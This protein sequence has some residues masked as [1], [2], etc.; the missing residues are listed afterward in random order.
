[1]ATIDDKVVSM[2][3]ESSKFEQGVNRTISSLEKLKAAL[4]FPT[5]GK[6]LEDID[7]A[8]KKVDFGLLARGIENVKNALNTLRL[9]GIGVLTHL[10]NVA[11]DTGAK[12]VKALTLDPIKAGFSE[13]TTNLNAV[14]TIL[15]NTQAAGVGL[16]EVNATL[17][18]LNAYSDK[19]IYNFSQMAKN[20]GT[21][22]AA[23]VDL[24]TATASIKG[25]ANLAALSGSSAEQAST[26]MYQ[27]S[28]AIAAGR[29]SLMDWNSVV[30]AG[31]GGTVFQR[32]LAQTAEAMGTLKDGTVK[33]VGPMKNVQ[34]AGESF[35][36]SLQ[37]GP[38]KASWL[39]SE[40]LTKTLQQFTGDLSDAEL[41]AMGFNDAQIKAI[42]QTAQTAMHAATEVKTLGQVF[43]VAKE[44]AG[45][46]WAQ[47]FQ[48]LFGTFT[49]AKTTFTALSNA[50]NGFI[51]TNADARNKVLEDWKALGGRTVLIDSIKT[52]FHNLGLIIAPIKEAFRD[53]FPA[54]TG[55]DLYNLTLRFR[56]FAN[57]LKP[58]EQTIENLKRTF[59][60][61]FALLDIGKQIISGIFGVF[62][63]LFG[64]VGEGSGGFL[65]FTG[66]IGDFLVK[67]DEAL[68]KGDGLNKFF[69]GLAAVLEVPI[70]L[71][72]IL[73]SALAN[74]FG[75]F[76]SGGFSEQMDGM[77]KAMTPFQ[78]LMAGITAAWDNFVDSF[79]NVGSALQPAVDAIIS[80]VDGLGTAI[81]QAATNMNFDAILQVIRTGLFAGLVLLLKNFF[82]KGSLLEQISKGFG[83]GIIANIAGS[84]KALEGS[85]VAMQQNI[86]A[87]TL[88]EIA[89]A[90]ALLAASVVALSFVDPAK[91][92]TALAAIGIMMGELLGAMAILDKI[93]KS[94]GFL[95]L[96]IIAAGLVILAGA[97]DLLVIAVF[98]LSQLSWEELLKGL[99][100][101]GALLLGISAASIPLSANS[102]GMI[103]AGIGIGAI[104]IAMNLLALAMK[105]FAGMSWG[106]IA[107]GLT[108]VASGLVVIAGAM[109]IMPTGMVLQGAAIIAIAT[110]LK[111]LAGVVEKFGGMNWSSM[112]KGMVGI[113]GALVIIAGA[114]Q[115]MPK[116]M[117]LQAAALLILS[118]ALGKIA[119]AVQSMGGMSLGEIAR[120]LGTLAG[121]L[122]ILAA[123]LYLMSG[124][125]AGAAALT[126][127]AAGL[128]LLVPAIVALGGMSWGQILKGL[129]TLAAALTIIGIAGALITPVIPSLLGLGAA[130]LLIGAGL[131]LAGAGI[132]LIGVG[133]SALIVALPAGVGVLLTALTELQEGIINNVKLL[134]LGLLEIVKALA[135]TAPQFVEALVTI[136]NSLLDV[137]IQASPK[138]A[139][140]FNA[141]LTAALDILSQNQGRI[142][143]A[144]FDLLK[145]LLQGISDNVPT[146]V[147]MI[148]DIITKIL[149]AVANNLGR[150]Y[151]AGAQIL[152]SILKGVASGIAGVTTAALSIITRFLA[153]IAGSL[154]RIAEAGL[155]IL[156]RFLNAIASNLGRV[157]T[158]AT[159]VIVA[160]INGIA[161]NLPRVVT[162][163][164]NLIIKFIN[165]I[166]QSSVRLINAGMKAI[167]N[168]L[169]GVAQAIN[170]H[171]GEMRAAGFRVGV[172]IIDGM[173][174][175]LLSKAGDLFSKVSSIM[176]KAMGL[177]HKIP[178]VKSPSTV[179]HRIGEEIVNGLVNGIEQNAPKAYKSASTLAAEFLMRFHRIFKTS[180]YGPSEVMKDIGK[181]VTHGFAQGLIGFPEEI[182]K[183]FKDLNQQLTTAMVTA[184][185]TIVTEQKK[186]DEMRAKGDTS[187]KAF[188]EAEKAIALN[189]SI[190]AR[191]TAGHKV[192]ISVLKNQKAELIGVAKE[193]QTV[194]EKL[195][196][197]QDTLVE[198]GRQ[199][200]QNIKTFT[201]QY[202]ALPKIIS[203]DEE[204]KPVD[205]LATYMEAL[206]TQTAAVAT[207]GDT[208][209]KLR[210]LGLDDETYNKLLAEGPEA[211]AFATQLLS[212]GKTAVESL[213]TLDKELKRVSGTLATSA[214]DNLYKA[215][216]DA[217][218]GLIRGLKSQKAALILEM[219]DMAD[220]II[221]A[222]NRKLKIKS[223]SQVFAEIGKYAMEGM[224]KGFSDSSQLVTNAIDDAAQDALTAMQRSMR[225][226]SD[227][228]TNEL[229]P[230]P[231]ITPIL[232]LTQI[233]TQAKELGVLTT[234]TPITATASYGQAALI[235]S[236]QFA[237]QTA[238]QVPVGP[239][240]TSV[241]F[242]QNN[243]SPE[244]L[245][246]IEIYRQTKNQLSQLKSVLALS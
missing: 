132:F 240:G 179:T 192:M 133:L 105:Q 226:I 62:A 43:E 171:S 176:D 57:A 93:A 125:I 37:A 83:G 211:Q 59:R 147:T 185:K 115:L 65:E 113:A 205:I 40:V 58:S 74:L 228:V 75:G 148:V 145:A 239:G 67:V 79:S 223:P 28:Q 45:S 135:A 216:A 156:T 66:S 221:K 81:G 68:K 243:Y 56:D 141:L 61:L 136:L 33:L 6:G 140:A 150:I 208:L 246:E 88:K 229:N 130:L 121:A 181:F 157:I 14:Q 191:S 76:S 180:H 206:K 73:A 84:F 25:I 161:N 188:Q 172:A 177:M 107:K 120:G 214:A 238:E 184:R 2:S 116:G 210:G 103:R 198:L 196:A 237:T 200:E 106:E 220:D 173:T 152:I 224:A 54:K 131:A 242:E 186:L 169:N 60:G 29:V 112:V 23:G 19:T 123:A 49:E 71:I 122:A 90:I 217:A 4:H 91:L 7:K 99:T 31:M 159:N 39:T 55:K 154:G 187:S 1:M 117:V 41:A 72:K 53:I 194:S 98:A 245:T 209:Q 15:A 21:F 183:V 165:A 134:I 190:L 230:N 225:D 17:R 18:E 96:P 139:E 110:G 235:S 34:I 129:V 201:E 8:A 50:I 162:A 219:E 167:V 104:A 244:S 36:Q 11:V 119:E 27:L 197:A 193:F 46:G 70:K 13:Y 42:Q 12:F 207:Y 204:G 168:F 160:F 87:K 100:G 82:G 47:T 51:N 151:Q 97:I 26:A 86:K 149:S 127:A 236:E 63:R 77:T 218:K 10:A 89:I 30:N 44:T 78:K 124:A 182:N 178:G 16:K 213:N 80:L 101:V 142:I 174:G 164:T 64:V 24:G 95:K 3:F 189:E 108:S 92:N 212:G 128:A 144:G 170:A 202:A 85:M 9:V 143:Q 111:I 199:R 222:F 5:A 166:E 155:S 35:R 232:D 138:I 38:G 241:K 118:I 227:V 203:E 94:G 126:V 32:A 20:I 163:A 109:R 22:T 195:K 102:A 233:R 234:T 215:G 231:V 153:A 69:D 146:L 114:M 48:I 175:G 137:V 158:A 52:A